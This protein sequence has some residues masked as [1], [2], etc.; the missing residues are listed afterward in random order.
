MAHYGGSRGYLTDEMS[1]YDIC[2]QDTRFGISFT[3]PFRFEREIGHDQGYSSG[4]GSKNHQNNTYSPHSLG[5]PIHPPHLSMR[6]LKLVDFISRLACGI[7]FFSRFSNGSR[8]RF[9]SNANTGKS[10][11]RRRAAQVAG[12]LQRRRRKTKEKEQESS[13]NGGRIVVERSQSFGMGQRFQKL[14]NLNFNNLYVLI[15]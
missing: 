13:P 7:Q 10:H 5:P 4:N 12:K 11:H 15:N 8:R 6:K 2:F 1:R 3:A 14:T 9:G